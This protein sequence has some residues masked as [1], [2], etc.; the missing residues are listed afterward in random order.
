[1][2]LREGRTSPVVTDDDYHA[3]KT[4]RSIGHRFSEGDSI[5]A[6][7]K[8]NPLDTAGILSVMTIWWL[9]PLLRRGFETPLDESSVWDLPAADRVRPLQEKF[10]SFYF[11]ATKP[12]TGRQ[13]YD[14]L[15]EPPWECVKRT[16][17]VAFGCYLASACL[18]L[19]Q[20][21]LIRAIIKNIEGESNMFGISTGYVLAILLGLAA[22]CGATAISVGQFLVTRVSCNARMIVINCA[23]RKLLRLSAA[24]RRTMDTGEILTFIGVDSD[25]VSEAYKLGI[26]CIVSPLMLVTVSIFVGLQM[27]M[28]VALAV[29]ITKVVIVLSSL[30]LAKQIG[31]YRRQISSI[32]AK[33][34]KVTNEMLQGVRVVKL[35]GWEDVANNLIRDIR[36]QEIPCYGSLTICVLQAQCLYF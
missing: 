18:T 35:Y 13:D 27:G 28:T 29:A 10:D 1:M 30:S 17:S 22:F 16:C 21:F 15:P 7:S 19:L 5:E 4:S 31:A 26:W 23:Y 32:G 11:S 24:A 2:K 3:L 12:K 20:P 25:R 14:E 9:H 33:R 36:E 6:E 8:E 34:L